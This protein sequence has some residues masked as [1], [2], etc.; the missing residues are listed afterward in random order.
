MNLS[1][2]QIAEYREKG[3]LTVSGVFPPGQVD[4]AIADA[5]AWSRELLAKMSEADKAWYVDGNLEGAAVLRKIDQPVF[6]REVFRELARDPALVAMVHDLIGLE[7]SV[8]FSQVFMKPARGGGP[9]PAH[10][11]NAYFGPNDTEGL[12]TVWVAL[13]D[14]DEANGCLFYADGSH[15]EP[16]QEHAAPEAEPFNLQLAQAVLAK[17]PMTAALVPKG[18]VSFHHGNVYHQSSVNCSERPRRAVTM[19]YVNG[20]TTFD[21]PAWSFDPGMAVKI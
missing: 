16:V 8:Y 3:H 10:Q 21:H 12:V 13:D 5:E 17:Y 7:L 19:H 18:G 11:D 20:T 14:A 1:A 6:C 2:E 4:A 15:R 9:K